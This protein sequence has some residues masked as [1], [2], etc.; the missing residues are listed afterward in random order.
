MRPSRTSSAMTSDPKP[1][2]SPS[3]RFNRLAKRLYPNTA[4][5]AT[6]SAAAVAISASATP[7]ATAAM[8]PDPFV[9]IPMNAT[10]TPSTV[11]S[12]P[13]S[14]LTDPMVASHGMN[15]PSRSRSSDVTES[16]RNRSASTREP[17]MTPAASRP[18][19]AVARD[20]GRKRTARSKT[21]V[22][23]FGGP[24]GERLGLLQ[25]GLVLEFRHERARGGAKRAELTPL[26]EHD[27]PADERQHGE[28]DEYD[29][30][31]RRRMGDHLPRRRRNG[32]GDLKKTHR[33]PRRSVALSE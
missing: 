3:S 1:S 20:S 12:R 16:S 32:F 11:P 29:L 17:D 30:R 28:H 10:I 21:R 33:L 4:G 9:A 7:G 5:I 14:G 31:H 22:N 19:S 13:M 25:G 15:R 18:Y 2:S 23:G 26:R 6:A 24:L 8:L 27:R